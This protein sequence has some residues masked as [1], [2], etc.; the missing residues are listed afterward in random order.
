MVFFKFLVDGWSILDIS[1]LYDGVISTS[2]FINS[3]LL[4]ISLHTLS[5]CHLYKDM[6]LDIFLR[7]SLLAVFGHKGVC[8]GKKSTMLKFL[9][10][11][12]FGT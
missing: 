12:V 9:N 10:P 7:M 11:L 1:G 3:I 8:R 6:R 2:F 4:S 5:G